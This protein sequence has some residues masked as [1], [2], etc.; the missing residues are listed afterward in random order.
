MIIF[1]LLLH[2]RASFSAVGSFFCSSRRRHTRCALVTGVQ[3]CARPIFGLAAAR[4][5]DIDPA[6]P[7]VTLATAHP[8][9][10]RDA[11]ERATGVRP[12]L[13]PRLGNLF[14]RE[15][16]Y[17]KL[18]GDY[19]AVKAHIL[20]ETARGCPAA[21]PATARRWPGGLRG[22]RQRRRADR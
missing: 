6:V 22:G 21:H 11:V 1:L 9:K 3:T 20:A 14:D 12:P 18:P 5:L 17:E 2:Y 4:S 13:P 19:D 8:A 16:R 7:V 10:F 15:E